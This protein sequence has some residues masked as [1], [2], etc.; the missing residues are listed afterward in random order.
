[1][2]CSSVNT[3]IE[4]Y[5]Y[6]WIDS[7]INNEEN[8]EYSKDLIKQYP[9]IALFTQVEEALNFFKKIKFSITFIIVSG[10]L[11]PEFISQLKEMVYNISSVPK[12][13][14][15]TSESTKPQIEKLPIINDSFYNNGGYVLSFEEVQ[16]FLNNNL[17]SQ[18]LN[19]IRPLRR[20]KSETDAEFTFQYLDS[21]INILG[22]IYLPRLFEEPGE[23][24]CKKFDEY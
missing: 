20:E 4:N 3:K 19:Y 24:K 1:M 6:I 9:K 21:I 18:K 13:I 22:I 15:F 11:F 16:S 12:I 7:N 14:I 2:G 17:V 8:S 5:D 10:S 23:K